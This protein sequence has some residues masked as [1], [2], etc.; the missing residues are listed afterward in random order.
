MQRAGRVVRVEKEDPA[1]QS[2]LQI[3]L[4][5]EGLS[6]HRLLGDSLVMALNAGM[7]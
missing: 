4:I 2:F 5:G 3:G 6:N 7:F 1:G